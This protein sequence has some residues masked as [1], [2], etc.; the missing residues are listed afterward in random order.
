MAIALSAWLALR[1]PWLGV[2]F[3]P[4]G[5]N[6]LQVTG[7]DQRGPLASRLYPGD[8]VRALLLQNTPIS[9][10]NYDHHLQP[11]AE[12]TFDAY[13]AYLDKEG[14]LADALDAP[15]VTLIIN[16]GEELT[17]KPAPRR[18]ISSLPLTFWLL[19]SYGLIAL[20]IALSVWV[21]LPRNWPARLLAISGAGMFLAT[22]QHS[23][24]EVR[25]LAL[26][27]WQF[28]TL[29]RVNHIRV[30]LLLLAFLILLIIYPKPLK[31]SQKLIFFLVFAVVLQQTNENLQIFDLPLHSYYLPLLL[32]Y[33][34]GTA[35]VFLQWRGARNNP[36]DRAALRWFFLSILI[37]M[38]AGLVVYF[39]PVVLKTPPIANPSTMV[40]L[41]VTLYLGFAL[42]ILRYRLFHLERWWFTAWAWFLGGLTVVLVD[43]LVVTS[44]GLSHAHALAF[45][46]IAV[47]WIYFPV[48]QWLWRRLA[49][50]SEVNM[51]RHIPAFV[52]ALYTSPDDRTSPLWQDLLRQVFQPL[53]LDRIDDTIEQARLAGNGARLLVPALGDASGGISLLYG[54]GGRRLYCTRDKEIAQALI[55]TAVRINN[56]RRAREAGA[57]QE[58]QRIMRDLHDDVGGRLLTLIHKAP[59]ERN[60]RLARSAL[61]ALREAIYAL[62]HKRRYGL[63][64]LFED[65]HGDLRERLAPEFDLSWSISGDLDDI[66]LSPRHYINLRRV[67]DEAITNAL[68]HGAPTQLTFQA[69]L[70]QRGELLLILRNEF[71]SSHFTQGQDGLPGRGLS[72]MRTRI[73]E[74]NGE[75]SLYCLTGAP[76]EFCMEARI[77]LPQQS[78]ADEHSVAPG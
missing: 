38:G 23:L 78:T 50:S 51:E 11:H 9:V 76:Y 71:D 40:G 26:S 3:T 5:M 32:Y 17:F 63:Q 59:N 7:V 27:R 4:S 64:E 65:W 70:N 48:R 37:A 21:F 44:F 36:T 33:P 72:N 52:E 39:L 60:E 22:W 1:G 31:H 61:S 69:E 62:D 19:H 12:P 66:Y 57:N 16:D 20:L 68:K 47:G 53:S 45:S 2:Q 8:Y 46:V 49:A 75:L 14:Q 58:R 43:I 77:P 35:L 54:Q 6:G 56:V 73:L 42:G 10:D 25:E 13:N 55:S 18:P 74:L 24:W 29:M 41:V 30:H 34:L 15:F 28:D 67:L